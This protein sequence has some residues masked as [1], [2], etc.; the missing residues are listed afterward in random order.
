MIAIPRNTET[1]S[2]QEER[3]VMLEQEGKSWMVKRAEGQKEAQPRLLVTSDNDDVE[4]ARERNTT[5]KGQRLK[6]ALTK[7][8]NLGICTTDPLLTVAKWIAY[9]IEIGAVVTVVLF[10]LIYFLVVITCN[11]RTILQSFE[12]FGSFATICLVVGLTALCYLHFMWVK[13]SRQLLVGLQQV[14]TLLRTP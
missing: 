7:Y 11:K 14:S 9:V 12:D 1:Q 8:F 13:P 3:E 6:T 10:L 2:N 4:T 5:R